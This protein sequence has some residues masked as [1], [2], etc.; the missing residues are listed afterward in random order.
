MTPEEAEKFAHLIPPE[1]ADKL[2][3]G[4]KMGIVGFFDILGYQSFLENNDVGMAVRAVLEALSAE[5]IAVRENVKKFFAGGTNEEFVSQV[6]SEMES[7]V[8]SD[9]ILL[10]SPYGLADHVDKK[11][12]HW[13]IYLIYV[14]TLQ[15]RLFK[16]GLPI[17][18]A[19]AVG[20][21]IVIGTCFAGRPIVE[22]F[23][24][25]SDI[26]AAMI[27]V[28]ESAQK[29]LESYVKPS[30]EL[31]IQYLAPL[32]KGIPRRF[33]AIN[34]ASFP[35]GLGE[36]LHGDE[37][38]EVAECFWKHNKDIEPA[39]LTKLANTELFLRFLKSKR[40]Y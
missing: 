22:A 40:G 39:A 26:D 19:I 17:R 25:T 12:I 23:R 34:F 33:W 10:T 1:L 15:N 16:F 18:G 5:D 37:R 11:S 7:L 32:K 28:A 21:Y 30:T 13:L 9:T 31:V 36:L 38:R 3:A 24:Q 6:L 2:R 35:I 27:L 14:A 4:S 8:F 29:D 20:E